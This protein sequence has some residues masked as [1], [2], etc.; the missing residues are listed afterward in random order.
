MKGE[1][2]VKKYLSIVLAISMMFAICV[3]VFAEDTVIDK[4]S[5]P[6]TANADVYTVFDVSDDTYSVTIPAS[7]EID[8]DDTGAKDL[9]YTVTTDLVPGSKVA[10][11]V[12]ANNNGEM[13]REAGS[14]KL[15]FTL[16]NGDAAEFT[17][18]NASAVPATVPTATI[19]SFNQPID[20]YT[21][22]VTFTVTYTPA[23]AVAP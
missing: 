16:A 10:V 13:T 4:D 20:T 1:K 15:T 6:Q 23:T 17:G 19:A 2:T 8:W 3:P 7:Y 12:A 18:L 5:N 9:D 11:S 21:G 14:E 22:S